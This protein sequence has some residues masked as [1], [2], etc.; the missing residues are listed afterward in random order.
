MARTRRPSRFKDYSFNVFIN[1]PFDDAY[2]PLFESLVFAITHCGFRP[3]C[4]LEIDDGSQVRVDKIFRIIE[5]CRFGLHD[6]S[7]AELDTSSGLPRFNM[8]L[9]LGMFL[10]AKRFGAERQRTKVCLILD[11]EPYRYQ[12]FISDIAGQDIRAHGRDLDR[13]IAVT[14][15]WLRASSSRSMPGGSE[16]YRQFREFR[17]QLPTLCKDLRL[18]PAEVTFNDLTNMTVEWLRTQQQGPSGRA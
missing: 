17:K 6:L 12:K 4:A 18:E 7:R 5:E 1:C 9:E 8:P 10:A 16:I 14:R 2:K 3:R 11:L 15:D 13:A